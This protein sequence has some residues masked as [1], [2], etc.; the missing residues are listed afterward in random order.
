M[1]SNTSLASQ[2][3]EE[4]EYEDAYN[5]PEENDDRKAKTE[6]RGK[7]VKEDKPQTPTAGTP[8]ITLLM[9]IIT[10]ITI[11]ATCFVQG[12]SRPR[13]CSPFGNIL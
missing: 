13:G 9:I 5:H 8:I 11:I 10:T 2:S 4:H 6:D 3:S 12:V 7:D 1:H